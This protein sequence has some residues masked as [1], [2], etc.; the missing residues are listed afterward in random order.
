MFPVQI[1]F[2]VLGTGGLGLGPV[3]F[4]F[5][6]PYLCITLIVSRY[7]ISNGQ[8]DR[9][10]MFQHNTSPL[11][12]MSLSVNEQW[13]IG[14]VMRGFKLWSVDGRQVKDT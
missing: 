14:T 2:L 11:L 5:L 6:Y 8:W 7:E 9:E 13:A 4:I 3:C 1:P 10:M 12:M